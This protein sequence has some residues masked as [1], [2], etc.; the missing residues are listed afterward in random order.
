MKPKQ[1][2]YVIL[3]IVAV[4]VAGSGYGYYMGLQQLHE[5]S[6]S[7]ATRLAEQEAAAQQITTLQT[8]QH[9]YTRDIVPIIPLIDNALPR[10]K[11][12]TEILAQIQ[13]VASAAGLPLNAVTMPNPAGLPSDVSQTIKAD[14][15]LGLPINFEVMGTYAQLQ[16][17]LGRVEN[18][19]R[20]TNVT[21]LT[22]SH[23]DTQPNTVKY[24]FNLN[25]YI[26]P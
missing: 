7:L 25:A 2:F 23:E 22:I 12:Q 11:K 1:F 15:V 17:F 5:R 8:L 20:F 13:R 9:Q 10:V 6:T 21:N 16:T 18:L 19:N 3:G 24:T 4:L 14:G 26:K